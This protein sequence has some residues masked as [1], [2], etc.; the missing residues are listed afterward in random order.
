MVRGDGILPFAY[1]I[2]HFCCYKSNIEILSTEGAVA[3]LFDLNAIFF[4]GW[5]SKAGYDVFFCYPYKM[6]DYILWA[7]VRVLKDKFGWLGE[8]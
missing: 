4:L 3:D 6:S 8:G 7:Y 5:A 1:F 2:I